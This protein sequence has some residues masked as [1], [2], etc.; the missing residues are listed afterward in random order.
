MRENIGL[1]FYGIRTAIG[2]LKSKREKL[3]VVSLWGISLMSYVSSMLMPT[4]QK[5]ITDGVYSFA[6]ETP[7][8]SIIIGG[9]AIFI[10][11]SVIGFILRANV[12]VW[13]DEIKGIISDTVLGD[14][15]RKSTEIKYSYFEDNKT[16]EQLSNITNNVPQRLSDMITWR[17]VPPL[18]GGM[19]S[20]FFTTFVLAGVNSFIAILVAIGNVLSIVF[21]YKRMRDNYYLQRNQIP[22]RRVADE[23]WKVL[24]ERI[25]AKEVNFFNIKEYIEEKWRNIS[26]Q[27]SKTNYK[28]A[29]KYSN[30]LFISDFVQVFFKMAALGYVCYLI[31][32]GKTSVGSFMLVYGSLSVFNGYMSDI[33]NAFISLGENAIYIK[34]WIE[35]M[36]LEEENSN[37]AKDEDEGLDIHIE[38]LKFKYKNSDTYALKGINLDIKKGEHIAVVG[39]NGSGKSTFV[40]L[41]NVFYDDY[42]GTIMLNGKDIRTQVASVRKKF[43]SVFQD[44]GKYEMSIYDNI[45]IGDLSNNNSI[46]DIEKS[47]KESNIMDFI[48]N[49][50]EGINTNIGI[51]SKDGI[52]LSGGQWQKIAISRAI[53]KKDAEL[54]ILDEPTAALDPYAESLI[55]EQFLDANKNKTCIL[56][57][58]RLGGTKFADRIIVFDSGNIAEIGTHKELMEKKGKYYEMYLSQA[59]LYM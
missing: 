37:N 58:H 39:E 4:V 5:M 40:S 20:L 59:K 13:T 35:Y 31:I 26:I 56:I 52:E 2:I 57:S 23:Y 32:D 43:A 11:C 14:I 45:R 1:I 21:Y 18:I 51:Y 10:I 33:S 29:V 7:D 9:L 24:T 19:V 54:L 17:T 12:S 25:Y 44:F 47:I 16:Y 36:E 50:P 38:N 15:L 27:A 34:D 41:L 8:Y 46:D 53:I 22:Q 42:E 48:D 3:M 30:R 28:F 6:T 55:Y 49:L